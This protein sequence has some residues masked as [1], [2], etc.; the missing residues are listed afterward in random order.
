MPVSE[1]VEERIRIFVVGDIDV[2]IAVE[3]KIASDR[4]DASEGELLEVFGLIEKCSVALVD[5]Q[6]IG[7]ADVVRW[8]TAVDLAFAVE[9]TFVG[10]WGPD[11]VMC[12][13]KIEVSVVF[14]VEPSG[15]RA[16]ATV[17]KPSPGGGIFKRSIAEVVK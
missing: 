12:D 7:F 6:F 4:A 3:V 15:R 1:V 8:C 13:V 9:A 10:F 5:P 2:R 17:L 14:K 11:S 16:P